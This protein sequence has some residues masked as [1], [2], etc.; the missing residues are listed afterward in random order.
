[1]TRVIDSRTSRPVARAASFAL[2]GMLLGLTWPAA[3]QQPGEK[4]VPVSK[5]ER[6]NR[7]PVSKEVLRVKL[8]K[9]FETT[10]PN[11]LHVL[12]LEDHRFPLVDV[13]L[14]ILGA[15]ATSDPSGIP[16]LASTTAA[17]LK[18]GTMNRDS[19]EIA[20][21]TERLGAAISF[22]APFG[23]TAASMSASGLSDNFNAWFAL[24]LDQLLDPTFPPEELA[25]LKQRMAVRLKQQRSSP[26]FLARERT[27]LALYCANPDDRSTCLPEGRVTE[28]QE[29]LDAI[30]PDRLA[31]WQRTRYVPQNGL[32]AIAGD[33]D[34]KAL[35]AKLT[36]DL[37]GWARTDQA[38]QPPPATHAA[39]ARRVFLVDRPNSVQT[40]LWLGNVAI[41]RRDPDYIPVVVANRVLGAGPSARLFL[42][43]R[44][45]KGY[46]YGVYSNF[47][48]VRYAGAWAGAG[49]VRRD[50][51]AGALHEF[52]Y[53]FTRLGK[54]PVSEAELDEARR[55]V[56]AGFALSL[57]QPERLIGYAMDRAI[58][59][60]PAD[61]WDTYPAKISA[62]TAADVTRVAAKYLD[63]DKLQIVG[64]GEAK[65]V[66]PAFEKYGAVKLYD[67]QGKPENPA[68]GSGTRGHP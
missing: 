63:P 9:P 42:N 23:G 21:E 37:A 45:E 46:T 4:S 60:L 8:P 12:I 51:T 25:K 59:S 34:T 57:E 7:A 26:Q 56:V 3:A 29:S 67:T 22:F 52:L 19:K 43:L 58:Y 30:T 64:V 16:G 28:T 55:S 66:L 39:G 33:V 1:M 20:E 15:G 2:A 65:Q 49:D 50:A 68:T 54:E 10:L 36:A 48:A 17:M 47:T 62:V 18:E 44:E 13:S 61:Y 38:D 27:A 53:E 5:A 14:L 24:A 35:V 11:G 31:E 40:T 32:L 41:D 6:L